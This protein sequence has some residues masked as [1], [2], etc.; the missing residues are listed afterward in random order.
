MPCR[1]LADGVPRIPGDT[2]L[3]PKNLPHAV[4]GPLVAGALEPPLV[5]LQDGRASEMR[6]NGR[7]NDDIL[8]SPP[9][10][11][12]PRPS[13]WRD[14]VSQPS[15]RTTSIVN[16]RHAPVG[17][18]GDRSGVRKPRFGLVAGRFFH[19]GDAE[20][21]EGR[22]RQA[23]AITRHE[24]GRQPTYEPPPIRTLVRHGFS[25]RGDCGS[26]V[27]AE[28]RAVVV[29]VKLTHPSNS[30]AWR[31]SEENR[32]A[33]LRTGRTDAEESA[34]ASNDAPCSGQSTDFC[35]ANA[36]TGRAH[37]CGRDG[38]ANPHTPGSLPHSAGRSRLEFL[39]KGR[40]RPPPRP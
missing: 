20:I 35:S 31:P 3:T 19:R 26:G 8:G 6:T 22:R 37:G 2:W 23:A 1:A 14:V 25:P 36:D 38:R 17:R 10:P 21:G 33:R 30:N 29:R 4:E 16:S 40:G 32:W 15:F 9:Q 11:G 7:K 5:R 39:T 27:S 24:R 34:V 18:V 13:G 28:L 12:E